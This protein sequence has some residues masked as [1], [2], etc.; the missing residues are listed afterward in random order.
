MA[1][2]RVELVAASELVED[3]SIY[4]RCAVNGQHVED[5]ARAIGAGA[6]VPPII[7]CRGSRI[8]ID[9]FHR[10]HAYMMLHGERAEVPVIWRDYPN[11]KSVRLLASI[12]ANAKHG[13]RLN[14][15]D[16]SRCIELAREFA[17]STKMLAVHLQVN[18][19]A[20]KNVVLR[21]ESSPA[22][23]GPS[24]ERPR[25]PMTAAQKM[26][27]VQC[28]SLRKYAQSDGMLQCVTTLSVV[29]ESGQFHGEDER[30]LEAL[31][32]LHGLIR[33][34]VPMKRTA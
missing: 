6:K 18:E 7:A 30:V 27:Y 9:G 4:P 12:E 23:P 15:D 25:Q 26:S 17:V 1:S 3:D 5:L 33:Q 32:K 11:D 20:V 21:L 13:L 10:R 19:E 24:S 29:I 16:E 34:R 22:V 2:E 8:I 31:W 28:D 14:R